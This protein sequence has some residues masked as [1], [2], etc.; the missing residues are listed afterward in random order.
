VQE[1]EQ[2]S[3][4]REKYTA[5]DT[6][7]AEKARQAKSKAAGRPGGKKPDPEEST[8]KTATQ[9]PKPAPVRDLGDRFI[10]RVALGCG[11]TAEAKGS[12]TR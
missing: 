3:A 12:R 10:N 1:R 2:L 6:P 11:P 4:L 9:K 5:T 8:A 7:V